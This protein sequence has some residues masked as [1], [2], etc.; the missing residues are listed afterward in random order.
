[1]HGSA[2]R[3]PAAGF[4]LL[5]VLI[6]VG[7][8]AVLL[9]TIVVVVGQFQARQRTD[10]TLANMKNLEM[11]LNEYYEKT[12]AYPP[13]VNPSYSSLGP[14]ERRQKL[15]LEVLFA[16]AE[17]G[18]SR[19]DVIRF[20]DLEFSTAASNANRVVKRGLVALGILTEQN[21]RELMLDG[22]KELIGYSNFRGMTETE[23]NDPNNTKPRQI[24]ARSTPILI[25]G[26]PDRTF[27][28]EKGGSETELVDEDNVYS[29]G[30]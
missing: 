5:E 13:D 20:N 3:R 18:P 2:L 14:Q 21:A 28:V 22:W 9:A 4:T 30:Q 8:I 26:G 10:N 23:A 15:M 24:F 29:H 25:S 27:L 17:L 1:M 7:I 19:N 6:V 12:R 11:A 16:G